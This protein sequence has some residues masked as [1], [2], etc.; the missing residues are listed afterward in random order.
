MT[1]FALSVLAPTAFAIDTIDPDW[2][3]AC[4]RSC[5]RDGFTIEVLSHNDYTATKLRFWDRSAIEWIDDAHYEVDDTY[6]GYQT[7]PDSLAGGPYCTSYDGAGG[8]LIV[9]NVYKRVTQYDWSYDETSTLYMDPST[10][11]DGGFAYLLGL[12]DLY[13]SGTDALPSTCSDIGC[14]DGSDTIDD[15][16]SGSGS[17]EYTDAAGDTVS[18]DDFYGD[19][20]EGG[21]LHDWADLAEE[22]REESFYEWATGDDDDELYEE[23]RE[24]SYYDWVSERRAEREEEAR[25]D[26][27]RDDEERGSSSSSSSSSASMSRGR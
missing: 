2:T 27:G 10:A 15:S 18:F 9:G 6:V 4:N 3:T 12:V 7:T 14:A 1:L 26:D 16:D 23:E 20:D 8:H 25:E 22:E 17:W 21:G 19:D 5:E 24:G 13:G 11:C